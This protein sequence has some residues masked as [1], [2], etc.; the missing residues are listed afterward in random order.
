MKWEE[1]TEQEREK[2]VNQDHVS[3][4]YILIDPDKFSNEDVEEYEE[5]ER[6]DVPEE[7]LE[8]LTEKQAEVIRLHYNEGMSQR[9]IAKK[10]GL[11]HTT[12]QG[13]IERSIRKLQEYFTNVGCTSV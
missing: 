2:F 4:S 5:V 7:W 13:Y 10:L 12:V 11:G 3:R 8:C 1:M 9:K 6:G